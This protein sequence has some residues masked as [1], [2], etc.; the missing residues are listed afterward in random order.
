[1]SA[2][3]PHFV[4]LFFISP[5]ILF[6]ASRALPSHGAVLYSGTWDLSSSE[7][8][9]LGI[10]KTCWNVLWPP[11]TQSY[12][13][14]PM[15]A[16]VFHRDDM[17]HFVVSDGSKSDE[18]A[19]KYET[20]DD[21]SAAT[22]VSTRE[23]VNVTLWRPPTGHYLPKVCVVT[24]YNRLKEEGRSIMRDLYIIMRGIS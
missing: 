11:K 12:S 7:K 3:K 6:S 16:F 21:H 20:V 24:Q 23:H 2:L 13:V 9:V 17:C 19:C 22:D 15:A 14:S 10:F 8:R 5:T 18:Y 4:C 1:M